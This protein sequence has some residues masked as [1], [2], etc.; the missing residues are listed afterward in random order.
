MASYDIDFLYQVWYIFCG[1]LQTM[2]QMAELFTAIDG[3]TIIN[4]FGAC[5]GDPEATTAAIKKQIQEN[6]ALAEA[7]PETLYD[8][9]TEYSTSLGPGR[10]L[11]TEAEYAERKAQF[12]A[13]KEHQCLTEESG[14]IPDFRAVEYWQKAEGR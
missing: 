5:A 4:G 10:K 8:A 14:I 12:D 1:G 2:K 9:Y 6:S 11:V 3:Y 13:L 7:D